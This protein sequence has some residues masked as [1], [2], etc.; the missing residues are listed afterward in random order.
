MNKQLFVVGSNLGL[1][2]RGIPEPNRGK[3]INANIRQ[4][5]EHANLLIEATAA[6]DQRQ[7]NLPKKSFEGLSLTST[8]S[9][10]LPSP[11]HNPPQSS[12]TPPELSPKYA[13][14]LSRKMNAAKGGF[15]GKRVS[16]V[17]ARDSAEADTLPVRNDNAVVDSKKKKVR[18]ISQLNSSENC[19]MITSAG[20]TAAST[21]ST[22][23]STKR[24]GDGQLRRQGTSAGKNKSVHLFRKMIP[25]Q[26]SILQIPRL[27]LLPRWH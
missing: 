4:Q 14:G 10:S 25:R 15:S 7:K 19:S 16:L 17:D 2:K 20:T 26:R 21:I 3:A 11:T 24:M 18:H 1:S 8:P 9:A 5:Q 27:N 12:S 6:I 22:N 23:Q 13:E